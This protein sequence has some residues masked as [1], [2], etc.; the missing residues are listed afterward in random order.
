MKIALVEDS[1]DQAELVCRIVQ[2][3]SHE[4]ESFINGVSLIRALRDQSFDL[5]ILDKNLPDLS[6]DELVVWIR[7][8]VGLHTPVMFLTSCQAEESLVGALNAGADDYVS[9]PIRPAELA[10]RI[11]ALLRRAYP[12][13]HADDT[14]IEL[15][16][17]SLDAVTK[18][19]RLHGVDVGLAPKEFEVALYLF[20][21]VGRLVPRDVIE[22]A[23]WGRA[24]GPDSRTLDT[25]V[26]RVR[27]KMAIKPEHGFRLVN[28]YSHGFRLTQLSAEDGQ[29]SCSY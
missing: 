17:Y 19:A 2:S 5:F 13:S 14:V 28:V 10:A 4:C 3:T 16:P 21:N 11:V 6:G 1:E 9:K 29:V 25:H 18:T 26:S 7:R 23:V 12:S 15:G 24:I 20:G 22:K 8:T 27:T